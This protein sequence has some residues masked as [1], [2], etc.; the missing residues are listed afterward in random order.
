M[1]LPAK[2][3]ETPIFIFPA[4]MLKNAH[5]LCYPKAPQFKRKTGPGLMTEARFLGVRF[6]YA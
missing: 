6:S 5:V 2:A 3:I 4:F 1:M